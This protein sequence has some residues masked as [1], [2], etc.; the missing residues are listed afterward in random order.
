MRHFK[1][2]SEFHAFLQLPPP[3]HPLL[4]VLD[5]GTV[6][7]RDDDALPMRLDF[8]SISA[9][10]M[11][12][13][14]SKYGQ[15]SFDFNDGVMSFM[16][17]SQVFSMGVVNKD[18]AVEKS[19]WVVYI[20]PDFIWNTPLATSIKHYDFWDY[21]LYE[22]LFLSA[23]EEATILAI[24]QTIAQEHSANLDRFSKQIIV[25]QVE[26]LLH[27][28]LTSTATTWWKGACPPC[29]TWPST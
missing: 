4:S 18:E 11:R 19:G 15:H 3:L 7:H 21:S 9:K 23:K 10:R 12:N 24:I 14:H 26:S 13:V 17:P 27:L 2:I 6:P 5:V 25:S 20:H 16:A 29:A 1:T 8:Y 22:G 28:T